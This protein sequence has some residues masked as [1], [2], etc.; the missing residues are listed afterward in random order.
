MNLRFCLYVI[1]LLFFLSGCA[2]FNLADSPPTDAVVQNSGAAEDISDTEGTERN[3]ADSIALDS[4]SGDNT[5]TGSSAQDCDN[6]E[7]CEKAGRVSPKKIQAILDE[8]LDLCKV[9][10]DFWQNG[11][12]ENALDAL[13]QAYALI[14]SVGTYDNPKLIQ[15]KEDLRFMISKRILE[16]Y[17]SRNIVVNGNYNAIPVVINRHVQA[18]IDRFTK[19]GEINF[20]INS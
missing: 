19:G 17:A 5:V 12:L 16:I 9:S 7:N 14:I 8:A 18:E 1:T 11:E 3:E 4:T 2:Q 6:N 13:D 20:F 15:Q 10:Q